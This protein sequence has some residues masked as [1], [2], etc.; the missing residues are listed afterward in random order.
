MKED[1]IG[2]AGGAY[3]YAI[4]LHFEL[5]MDLDLPM[6]VLYMVIPQ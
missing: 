1:Q 2:N 3:G 6:K 5:L 4:H